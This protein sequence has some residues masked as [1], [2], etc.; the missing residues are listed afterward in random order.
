MRESSVVGFTPNSSAAPSGPLIFHPAWVQRR[1]EILALAPQHFRRRQDFGRRPGSGFISGRRQHSVESVTGRSKHSITPL[2]SCAWRFTNVWVFIPS[3]YPN[4][5]RTSSTFWFRLRRV[6]VI[7]GM[8]FAS[9]AFGFWLW[10]K[11]K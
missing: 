7:G 9:V 5:I 2:M 1:H 3:L 11:C 8:A 4:R 10:L 6:G